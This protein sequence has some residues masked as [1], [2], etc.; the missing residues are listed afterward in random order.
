MTLANLISKFLPNKLVLLIRPI[1]HLAK[2]KFDLKKRGINHYY[3]KSF[4]AWVV[5]F[6]IKNILPLKLICR[7]KKE[8]KRISRF[9]LNKKDV[10]WKWLNWIDKKVSYMMLVQVVVLKVCSLDI[11]M[12]Q[13]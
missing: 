11:C 7:S 6:P 5:F 9:G 4:Q 12:I 3:D 10:V 8:L 1:F 13:K 2:I